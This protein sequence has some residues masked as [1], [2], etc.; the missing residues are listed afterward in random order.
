MADLCKSRSGVGDLRALTSLCLA[1]VIT[2][3]LLGAGGLQI[4]AQRLLMDEQLPLRSALVDASDAWLELLKPTGLLEPRRAIMAWRQPAGISSTQNQP[5]AITPSMHH[6]QLSTRKSIIAPKVLDSSEVTVALVGDSMMA[7]NVAPQLSKELRKLGISRIISVYRSAAGLS[8]PDHFD[9][10]SEYPRFLAGR[11]PDIIICAIGANDAQGFQVGKRV[12]RFGE[13]GWSK[14]YATRVQRFLDLLQAGGA[15]IVW[16]AMP[17]MRNAAFDTRIQFI[18]SLIVEQFG[19]R[20]GLTI[21]KPDSWLAGQPIQQ[22]VEYAV[23]AQGRP[24]RVRAEDGIHIS[25]FGARR[26]AAS[27]MAELQRDGMIGQAVPK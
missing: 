18:N 2:A 14:E 4:W 6:A 3:L 20:P 16:I 5:S 23:S 21:L 1:F 26:I 10:L 19:N 22:Y 24:E 11:N 12:I 17:H 15:R 13:P 7:V 25:D 8:R 9:W 27:I